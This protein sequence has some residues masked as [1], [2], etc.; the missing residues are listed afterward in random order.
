MHIFQFSSYVQFYKFNWVVVPT[1]TYTHQNH[2]FS[3]QSHVGISVGHLIRKFPSDTIWRLIYPT[4]NREGPDT[5]LR[6]IPIPATSTDSKLTKPCLSTSPNQWHKA[7]HL[8]KT[9][10]KINPSTFNL[11]IPFT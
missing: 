8:S 10:Y 6:N 2:I 3:F 7:I 1:H 9:V 11:L 4:P 5:P